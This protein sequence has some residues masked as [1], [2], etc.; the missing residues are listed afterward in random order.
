M[1]GPQ[2]VDINRIA[3]PIVKYINVV[4]NSRGARFILGEAV[5][6]ALEDRRGPVWI[7]I[8]LD[9]QGANYDRD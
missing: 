7:A 6:Y 8:P 4:E 9:I 1:G 2:D 3:R 5:R